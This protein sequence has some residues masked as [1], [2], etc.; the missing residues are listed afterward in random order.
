MLVDGETTP[1]LIDPAIKIDCAD[2]VG[3]LHLVETTPYALIASLKNY[4]PG[5][6]KV[7]RS[8]EDA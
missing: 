1:Y 7:G 4:M 5:S 2:C 3:L 6:S 8:A